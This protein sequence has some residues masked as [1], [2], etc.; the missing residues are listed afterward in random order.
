MVSTPVTAFFKQCKKDSESFVTSRRAVCVEATRTPKLLCVNLFFVEI[1]ARA[2]DRF[3]TSRQGRRNRCCFR[4]CA[5]RDRRKRSL[6]W[7]RLWPN[8]TL[9]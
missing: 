2:A 6:S 7:R 8:E 3:F 5:V 4:H 1:A 9:P